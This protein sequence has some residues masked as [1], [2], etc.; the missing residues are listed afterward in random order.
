MGGAP[1]NLEVVWRCP[2]QESFM[3]E[4]C[5]LLLLPRA[6]CHRDFVIE[7]V[8][9]EVETDRL[10]PVDIRISYGQ[11]LAVTPPN[12]HKVALSWAL[13]PEYDNPL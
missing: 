8:Y 11:L 6:Y 4:L 12:L 3:K 1:N 10:L 5:L 13:L 9:H 7:H 2:E